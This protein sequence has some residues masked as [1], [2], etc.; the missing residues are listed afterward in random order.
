MV[1]MPT[2]LIFTHGLKNKKSFLEVNALQR[3]GTDIY[4]T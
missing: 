2:I 3:M 4:R 1:N